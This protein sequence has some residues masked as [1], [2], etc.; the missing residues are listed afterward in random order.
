M[1]ERAWKYIVVPVEEAGDFSPQNG[2]FKFN[3]N[4][5]K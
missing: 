2:R 1:P 3:T 4:V 5:P